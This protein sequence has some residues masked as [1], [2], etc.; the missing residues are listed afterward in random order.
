VVL[1]IN[2]QHDFGR[3][4]QTGCF[5]LRRFGIA[6]CSTVQRADWIRIFFD[7]DYLHLVN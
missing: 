7:A 6:A 4:S 2:A 1:F 5:G 3:D